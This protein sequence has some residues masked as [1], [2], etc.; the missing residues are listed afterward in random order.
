MVCDVVATNDET[1]WR[2]A[3]GARNANRTESR[4]PVQAVVGH[5][6]SFDHSPEYC[7]SQPDQGKRSVDENQ[8]P[9]KPQ[10][11]A[12]ARSEKD[13]IENVGSNNAAHCGPWSP[14][15]PAQPGA[16]SAE[17]KNDDSVD[18]RHQIPLGAAHARALLRSG[19][20]PFMPNK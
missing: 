8:Y 10:A 15:K 11:N 1:H 20:H 18:V 13:H 12:G 4:R 9:G 14:E 6:I 16:S 7:C 2:R 19:C 17:R 5:S 3:T